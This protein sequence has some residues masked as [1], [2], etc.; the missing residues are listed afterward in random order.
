MRS[1]AIRTH[2]R[3]NEPALEQTF[4]VYTFGVAL[5]DLVLLPSL[6]NSG[7]FPFTMATRTQIRN[8]GREC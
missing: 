8:V 3:H 6:A 2:R 4:P 1:V 7:L 5:N